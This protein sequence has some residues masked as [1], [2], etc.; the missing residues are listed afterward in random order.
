MEFLDNKL[1]IAV[2]GLVAFYLAYKFFS[3]SNKSDNK[4]ERIYQEHLDKILK[5]DEYKVKGRFE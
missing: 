4:S 5:S 3:L 2:V 1:L